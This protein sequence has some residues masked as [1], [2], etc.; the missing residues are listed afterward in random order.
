MI[1]NYLFAV[2]LSFMFFSAC[3]FASEKVSSTKVVKPLKSSIP[4]VTNFVEK[5]KKT[6]QQPQVEKVPTRALVERLQTQDVAIIIATVKQIG[7]QDKG[8][9]YVLK[10]FDKLLNHPYPSVRSEVLDAAFSF[11][12]LKPLL[13]ALTKCLNDPVEDIRQDASDIIGDIESREMI[14][15]FVSALTNQY[16]DVRENAEF[17]LLFWTD[18]EFTNTTDWVKWWNKNQKTFVFD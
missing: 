5:A 16:P 1:K 12:I 3:V 13:P 17:Y 9:R 8:S 4:V 15:V 10:E 11:D 7:K 6:A 14:G 2:I 18:E